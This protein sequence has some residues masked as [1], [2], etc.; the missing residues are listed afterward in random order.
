MKKRSIKN[1][2][3]NKESISN[4]QSAIFGGDA[5]SS[6]TKTTAGADPF[7]TS[8]VSD[9]PLPITAD[10]KDCPN[11]TLAKGCESLNVPCETLFC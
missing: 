1:L 3:L 11:N 4:I 8:I 2:A 6:D 10:V 5:C 9:G 7:T